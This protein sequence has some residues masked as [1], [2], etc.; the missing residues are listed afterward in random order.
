MDL[1]NDLKAVK[2]LWSEAPWSHRVLIGLAAL[3]TISP[4][5]S[6]AD[7][8]FTWKGLFFDA[9]EFYKRWVTTP[10]REYAG[11]FGLVWHSNYIDL[12]I[13]GALYTAGMIRAYSQTGGK[14]RSIFY[15]IFFIGAWAIPA[16]EVSGVSSA[17]EPWQWVGMICL[18]LSFPVVGRWHPKT[19]AAY[20]APILLALAAVLVA[21]A[22]NAGLS[23][24]LP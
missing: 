5:A 6:L 19:K 12:F 24:P 20:Y 17:P 7:V 21:G 4:L 16:V 2:K 3:L 22:I 13:L 9:I 1:V 23:R 15:T 8:I 18:L 14:L 11:Q 10:I